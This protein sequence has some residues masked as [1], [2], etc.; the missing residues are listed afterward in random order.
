MNTERRKELAATDRAEQPGRPRL[1]GEGRPASG[2]EIILIPKQLR[3]EWMDAMA[4]D[5][6]LTPIAYKVAG[7]IGSHFN[8][9]SGDTYVSQ[10]KLADIL[11]LALR[12]I[13]KAI[14]E[15]QGRGYLIVQGRELGRRRDGRRV[16]GGRGMA[17]TYAPAIDGE[18]VAATSSGRRF[19]DRVAESWERTRADASNRRRKDAPPCVH[20]DTEGGAAVRPLAAERTHETPLKDAPPCV[21]T[22]S[23]PSDHNPARGRA[24]AR[25]NAAAHPL[26]AALE[27]LARKLGAGT[28]RNWFGQV[29]FEGER[30]GTLLLGTPTGFIRD[31]LAGRHEPD[32]LRAWNRT[33]P[34]GA[35]LADRVDFVVR[36]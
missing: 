2:G 9:H 26:A 14:G 23:D 25:E 24:A 1:A 19:A 13:Q 11:K 22:L 18:R 4:H 27:E 36:K 12:T 16:R 20:S 15:L 30:A 3:A 31:Y 35:A 32:M 10:D 34:R 28:V 7:V 8:R 17:N 33:R 29:T 5:P 21:P 6:N